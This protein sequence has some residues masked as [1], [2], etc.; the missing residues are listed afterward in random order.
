MEIDFKLTMRGKAMCELI[1]G[2]F[3]AKLFFLL[4]D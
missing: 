4:A 2:L 3:P 1:P